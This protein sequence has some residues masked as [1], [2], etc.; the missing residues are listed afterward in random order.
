MEIEPK[1]VSILLVEDSEADLELYKRLFRQCADWHITVLQTSSKEE[2][3]RL[4]FDEKPDCLML[5]YKL[6]GFTGLELLR[7]LQ[8]QYPDKQVSAIILSGGG[9]ENLIAEVM[10]AGAKAFLSKDSLTV[11]ALL[12]A[13]VAAL[14]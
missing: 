11:E 4:F 5:D 12:S 14:D 13:I 2:A 6:P 8:I 1:S 10:N 7:E 3:L 9:D